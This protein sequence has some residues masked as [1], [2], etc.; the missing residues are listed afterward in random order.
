MW[1]LATLWCTNAGEHWLTRQPT[2]QFRFHLHATL[3]VLEDEQTLQKQRQQ[4]EFINGKLQA[5]CFD[6][7]NDCLA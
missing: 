3:L 7:I 6:G 4:E 1:H 5:K 2:L